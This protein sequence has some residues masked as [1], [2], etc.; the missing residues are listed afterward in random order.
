MERNP[1]DIRVAREYRDSLGMD[2]GIIRASIKP[3][4]D[5][6][7]P[8]ADVT[9][10]ANFHYHQHINEFRQILNT[11]EG[12]TCYV[13]IVSAN[14][15]TIHWRAQP[16]AEDIKSYFRHWELVGEVPY[17]SQEG[18]PHPREMFSF[19]FKSP[20]VERV[21]IDSI[22][23][24]HWSVGESFVNRILA[25]QDPRDNRYFRELVRRK[26]N[27]WMPEKIDKFVEQKKELI[28]DVYKNGL[29]HPLV[30]DRNMKLVDGLHRYL[31]LKVMREDSAIV[32]VF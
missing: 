21:S 3:D 2:Y 16:Y 30:V 24:E 14:V 12:K 23:Q 17:I 7:L 1:T 27:K 25:G 31:V 32:R 9:L 8:L 26:Q 11:L 6:G 13:L 10:L 29:K 20:K 19:L 15:R 5:L 4:V 28:L 18:D 22:V